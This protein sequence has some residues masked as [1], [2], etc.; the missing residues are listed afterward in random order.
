[1]S[2]C[3]NR[4]QMN[5]QS[6]IL[7]SLQLDFETVCFSMPSGTPLNSFALILEILHVYFTF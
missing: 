6:R 2:F 4:G 5:S 1:M 7:S 3:V